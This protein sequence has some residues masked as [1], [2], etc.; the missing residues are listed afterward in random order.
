[1]GWGGINLCPQIST[2]ISTGGGKVLSSVHVADT[3]KS[4]SSKASVIHVFE[5]AVCSPGFG[6]LV[7][8]NAIFF[9][10]S[11]SFSFHSPSQNPSPWSLALATKPPCSPSLCGYP[12]APAASLLQDSLV[13]RSRRWLSSLSSSVFDDSFASSH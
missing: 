13:R 8:C 1:M 3:N 9:F 7:M 10:F 2:S 11:V 6:R 4:R 12:E 5:T